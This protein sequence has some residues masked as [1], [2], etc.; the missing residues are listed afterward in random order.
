ML[1]IPDR[2]WLG[3]IPVD[4]V[5]DET[6]A[7]REG[8]LGKTEYVNQ[9]IVIDPKRAPEESTQQSYIHELIHWI[10]FLMHEH[11]LREKEA[12]V[13]IFATFLHQ[14]LTCKEYKEDSE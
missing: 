1:T 7:E 6:L 8:I 13:D 5:R 3:G 11:K 2:V 14:A 10:L 9:R 12:F 4:I